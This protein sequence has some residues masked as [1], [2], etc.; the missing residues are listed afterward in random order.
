MNIKSLFRSL[1]LTL[2]ISVFF[3]VASEFFLFNASPA[4]AQDVASSCPL[5]VDIANTFL[6]SECQEI[7]LSEA[8]DFYRY[9][10][11]DNMKYGRYLTTDQYSKNVDVIRNL[12]LNQAWGNQAT[13]IETVTLPAGTIIYKGIVAPQPPTEC[14]PGMGHQVFIKD[15]KNPNIKWSAGQNIGVEPFSCP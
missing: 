5:P 8:Q 4:F 6:N 3:A 12:A 2:L 7:Q 14:Y 15:S 13:Q 10:S 9:Y 11:T 1:G